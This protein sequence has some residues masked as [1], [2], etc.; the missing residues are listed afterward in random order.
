MILEDLT[1]VF[2]KMNKIV[3]ELHH[4]AQGGAETLVKNECEGGGEEPPKSPSSP[5][6]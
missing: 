3:E 1:K 5:S 6:S 4:M 2:L